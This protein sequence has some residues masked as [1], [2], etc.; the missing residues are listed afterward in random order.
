M[1]VR[2]TYETPALSNGISLHKKGKSQSAGRESIRNY[3]RW[4]GGGGGC[5]SKVEGT[6]TGGRGDCPLGPV[7]IKKFLQKQMRQR[8][9][10]GGEFA[11]I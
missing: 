2:R 4:C 3:G 7:L 5:E 10:M 8:K 1:R 6:D 9:K 11:E